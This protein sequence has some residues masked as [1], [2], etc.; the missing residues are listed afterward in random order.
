MTRLKTIKQSWEIIEIFKQHLIFP[1][2]VDTETIYLNEEVCYWDFRIPKVPWFKFKKD[3]NGCEWF[4]MFDWKKK[5]TT[6]IKFEYPNY[7]TTYPNYYYI[8]L[9]VYTKNNKKI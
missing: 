4:C 3:K 9:V 2:Y 6:Y 7:Y 1:Y 8:S 5:K